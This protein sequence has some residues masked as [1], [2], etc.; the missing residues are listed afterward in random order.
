[1]A[2]FLIKNLSQK[3]SQNFEN[4]KEKYFY[5]RM[6]KMISRLGIIMFLLSSIFYFPGHLEKEGIGNGGFFLVFLSFL[7]IIVAL[8]ELYLVKNYR[9][10]GV[11][12][13]VIASM[14]FLI[15][16]AHPIDITLLL[17][18][19]CLFISAGLLGLH[20]QKVLEKQ[21]QRTINLS[22]KNN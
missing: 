8:T 12:F 21:N 10:A 15:T 22:L 1:M 6:M 18:M 4:Q 7:L 20:L 2:T 19:F 9:K 11:L 14:L 16:P 3:D 17:I 13:L 5:M